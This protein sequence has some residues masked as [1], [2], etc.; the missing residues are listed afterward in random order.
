MV[1]ALSSTSGMNFSPLFICGADH[2]HAG[3]ERL[4]ED[5]AGGGALVEQ[6]LRRRSG[7]VVT[8]DDHLLE[9]LKVCHR[10]LVL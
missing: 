4:V 7:A 2:V 3:Q 8:G 6:P 5:V 10:I 1:R 9:R